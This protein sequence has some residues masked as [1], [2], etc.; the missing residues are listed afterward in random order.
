[1]PF[2]ELLGGNLAVDDPAAVLIYVRALAARA[3]VPEVVQVDVLVPG[4]GQAAAAHR[5]GLGPDNGG[6]RA[7]P[8]EAPTAPAQGW[9]QPDAVVLRAGGVLCAGGRR[10]RHGGNARQGRGGQGYGGQGGHRAANQSPHREP[11]H[12]TTP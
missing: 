10:D 6:G 9:R 4:A 1:M 2:S 12:R 11:P 8:D 3:L 7:M 5:V